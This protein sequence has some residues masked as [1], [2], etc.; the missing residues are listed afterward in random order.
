MVPISTCIDPR[1]LSTPDLEVDEV[2]GMKPAAPDFS[3]SSCSQGAASLHP[4]SVGVRVYSVPTLIDKPNRWTPV[5]IMV[6][7]AKQHLQ[8]PRQKPPTGSS[9]IVG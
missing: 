1:V 7:H 9:L 8:T 5:D 6:P 2:E 4:T 3:C